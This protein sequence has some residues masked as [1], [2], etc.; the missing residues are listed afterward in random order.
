MT[1]IA[2]VAPFGLGQKTTVWARTLPLAK[3]LVQLGHAAQ[4]IIP[5]WD[6]PADSGR[7]WVDEGVDLVNV[8][9]DGGIP[10]T[11]LRMLAQIE[12]AGPDII[13]I[14]KPRAHA[15]LV[16][17]RLWQ[18]RRRPPLF[19]DIDDW[20]QAWT[21]VNHYDPVTGRFLA[22][23]EEWGIRH[24]DAITAASRWLTEKAQ[25][26]SAA[27]P[28]LYLPNGVDVPASV[29]NTKTNE[30]PT[31]GT[32]PTILFFSRF[33]EVE[34]AWL[35]TFWQTLYA[36][37][38]D[39]RLVVAGSAIEPRREAPFHAAISEL[40]PKAAQAVSWRGFVPPA[41]LIDLY[42]Q[43]TCA[44]FPARPIPLQQAK[45]SVRLATTLLN[46][47]PVVAS[48]VG[49]QA[50][51]GSEGAARLV[52]AEATPSEFAAA[53]VAL[54]RDASARSAMV[55]QA[56]AHLTARYQWRDLAETLAEFYDQ[57]LATS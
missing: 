18:K 21:D 47:V 17:W 32:G 6:T 10:G 41:D 28:V 19:L 29:P 51:Y 57:A 48:A 13:H 33:V 40:G 30:A 11:V 12:E 2:F 36:E 49:E 55:S 25:R 44:I 4:I 50:Q 53:T 14:I 43:S 27:T 8:T 9:L 39:A 15:G 46:G 20:E 26:Y 22:W 35:A 5:P 37:F 45:C 7:S 54:L 23:Q 38:P 56:R 31:A 1:R 34:P 3:E 24:A 42:A 52:P 16:Q